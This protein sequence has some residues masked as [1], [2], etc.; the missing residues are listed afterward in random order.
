M[1]RGKSVPRPS[2]LAAQAG[3]LPFLPDFLFG[4]AF[5]SLA[6]LVSCERVDAQQPRRS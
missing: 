6:M 4:F 5:A 1:A 2:L 3:Y